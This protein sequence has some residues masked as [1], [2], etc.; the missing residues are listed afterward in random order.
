MRMAVLTCA[1][2]G[3]AYQP[4]SFVHNTK[5][6][7]G[8]RATVGCLDISVERRLDMDEAA[9]LAY[10]FGNRCDHRV[11]IDLAR[12]A[13]IGRD[14]DGTETRLAPY[15]PRSELVPLELDA[16]FAGGEALAYPASGRAL[17]YVCVDL[18][19]LARTGTPLWSCFREGSSMAFAREQLPAPR[20]AA[21]TTEA[22]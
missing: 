18:A 20:V 22:P 12:L 1:L 8:S 21:S 16:R 6:F 5:E 13:V 4:G 15:D 14:V 2:V 10:Q 7:A 17:E 11:A 19:T 9:V 3:C